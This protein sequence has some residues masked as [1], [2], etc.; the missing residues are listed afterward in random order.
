M[1]ISAVEDDRKSIIEILLDPQGEVA[2]MENLN[3][4]GKVI[5]TSSAKLRETETSNVTLKVADQLKKEKPRSTV[6][7]ENQTLEQN[8]Y[9]H[10]HKLTKW[11]IKN[12]HNVPINLKFE[13]NK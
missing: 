7:Y 4:E 1:L 13:I 12:N 10:L 11:K 8:Y 5:F 2:N 3:F 6:K 9:T